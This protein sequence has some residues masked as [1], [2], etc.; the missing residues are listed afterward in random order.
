MDLFWLHQGYQVVQVRCIFAFP[1]EYQEFSGQHF[2][3]VEVF[4]K[5]PK[6]P[7]P[8]E[9]GFYPVSRLSSSK[10]H[11]ATPT[12][13]S[14]IIPI[15]DIH[16]GCQLAPKATTTSRINWT[17]QQALDKCVDFYLNTDSSHRLWAL[18]KGF[19]SIDN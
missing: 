19:M 14:R 11:S 3:F 2:A 7:Q 8:R 1:V 15:S 18:S 12:P 10:G 17:S 4:S 6:N 5:F 16:Y 9:S 13:V